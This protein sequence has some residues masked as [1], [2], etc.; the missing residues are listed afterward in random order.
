M[1]RVPFKLGALPRRTYCACS[2]RDFPD[3]LYVKLRYAEFCESR[4]EKKVASGKKRDAAGNFFLKKNFDSVVG[5]KGLLLHGV[6]TLHFV[7]VALILRL[8]TNNLRRLHEGKP[9]CGSP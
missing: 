9:L 1:G 4:R 3:V 2:R 8:Q 7:K 6:L 5:K